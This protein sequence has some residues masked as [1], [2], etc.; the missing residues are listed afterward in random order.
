MIARTP[1]GRIAMPA[2]FD[3]LGLPSPRRDTQAGLFDT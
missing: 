1:R 3:H 2:A